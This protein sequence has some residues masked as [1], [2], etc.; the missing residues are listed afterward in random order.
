MRGA[1]PESLRIAA[2]WPT[3]HSG[4]R[5]TRARGAMTGDRARG[6][7]PMP[8]AV[9]WSAGLAVASVGWLAAQY[10]HPLLIPVVGWLPVPASALLG[11]VMCFRAAAASRA[12]VDAGRF[13][14]SL[15]V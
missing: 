3:S 10:D 5:G 12:I 1:C 9:W 13:W 2:P 8:P 6:A 4:S 14:S 15:G 11:A 7:G